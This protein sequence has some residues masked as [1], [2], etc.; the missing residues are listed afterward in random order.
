M[1][2]VRR[3]PP[4]LRLVMGGGAV[5]LVGIVAFV[6]G[7]AF[8]SAGGNVPAPTGLELVVASQPATAPTVLAGEGATPTAP[9]RLATTEPTASPEPSPV[10]TP[11]PA[12]ALPTASPSPSGKPRSTP[13]T[14]PSPTPSASWHV[15]VLMY[16]LIATPEESEDAQFALVVSPKLFAEQMRLLYDDGWQT[17]TAAELGRALAIDLRPPPKTFVITIDD[18]YVDGYTEAFPILREN[19]FRATYYLPTGRIGW[20]RILTARQVTEMAAAG[21]EMADHSVSHID[22]TTLSIENARAEILGAID[23][24]DRLLDVRPTTFAY[25]FGI[26]DTNVIQEV[27]A[28]GFSI[29]FTT[30]NA[31]RQSFATRFASPRVQ[32]GPTIS[33][34]RLLA[35]VRG[36]NG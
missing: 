2:F 33:A 22:L 10:A 34:A 17:I 19:G 6:A 28:A 1:R 14:T 25:P 13:R 20:N 5:A 31:C 18:G 8:G 29:A 32:V 9:T 26:Y 23:Y 35:T 4:P 15:P 3:V 12:A 21:M 27:D 16:H 11:S 30:A 7:V 24:L 36:C